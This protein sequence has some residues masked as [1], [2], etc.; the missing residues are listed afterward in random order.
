M[1]GYLVFAAALFLLGCAAQQGCVCTAEYNPVCGTDGK[2]YGNL[3][4]A[5]CAKAAV[6]YEGECDA[7]KCTDTDGGKIAALKGNVSSDGASYT[8]YCKEFGSVEEYYC[9]GDAAS[10]ASVPCAEGYECRDGACVARPPGIETPPCSDTDGKNTSTKGTVNASG[11]I[12]QDSCNDA[13]LVKEYY[14]KDGLVENEI[15][16]CPPGYRCRGGLC[17]KTDA[18][19]TDTDGGDD[20][21]KG[22]MITIKSGLTSG[23]YIDKCLSG[24]RLR[25][26]YCIGSDWV[27]YDTDCPAGYRCVEAAC[28]QD[29]CFDSDDGY[30]IFQEGAANKGDDLFRDKC[31]DSDSGV[32]YYCDENKIM[33]ATFQCPAGSSC[34]DG[35]CEG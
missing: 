9:D 19:C 13:K 12:Y 28:K 7:G 30:S 8:D 16:E 29:Q 20:I 3:C 6:A 11:L 4:T 27:T 5:N 31:T 24:T 33:N 1:R 14:C 15:S 32:E 17:E 10:V 25:E 23:E 2:T 35:R 26:Y 34:V 22:G 21:G 18:T